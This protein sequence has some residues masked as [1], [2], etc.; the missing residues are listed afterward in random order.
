MKYGRIPAAGLYGFLVPQVTKTKAVRRLKNAEKTP[1]SVKTRFKI[2]PLNI[3]EDC[4]FVNF[5]L[6]SR[7]LSDETVYLMPLNFMDL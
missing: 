4:R 6:P 3:P 2:A 7:R 5:I 1:K